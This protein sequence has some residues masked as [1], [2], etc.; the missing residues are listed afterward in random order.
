MLAIEEV[1][2][3]LKDMLPRFLMTRARVTRNVLSEQGKLESDVIK[4]AKEDSI[5]FPTKN[6]D[7]DN[8]S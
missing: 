6:T 5:I 7:F 3:F 2:A 1:L 4:M 8:Y